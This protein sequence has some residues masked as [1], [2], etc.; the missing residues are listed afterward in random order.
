MIVK[1]RVICDS[2][3]ALIRCLRGVETGM[4][5]RSEIYKEAVEKGW[6]MGR[7]HLCPACASIIAKTTRVKGH[8]GWY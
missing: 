7:R 3:T 8:K 5:D 6:S 2:G 1:G 4:N